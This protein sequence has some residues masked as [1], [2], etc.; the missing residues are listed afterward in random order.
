MLDE[1]FKGLLKQSWCLL[2][3]TDRV[4]FATPT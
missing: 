1:L 4:C 3:C 2:P